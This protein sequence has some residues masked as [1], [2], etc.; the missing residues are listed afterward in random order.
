MRELFQEI[1]AT[2]RRNKLRTVLTGFSVAWGIF[3]LIILL[4]AGNGLKNGVMSNFSDVSLNSVTVYGARTDKPYKGHP[5]GRYIFFEREDVGVLQ[6]KHEDNIV[7]ITGRF[8][9][10]GGGKTAVNG[11]EYLPVSLSGIEANYTEIGILRLEEGRMINQTDIDNRRKVLIIEQYTTESLFKDASPIG[12]EIVIDNVTYTVVGRYKGG[13]R[14]N[15]PTIFAPA[16][17]LQSLYANEKPVSQIQFL[18]DGLPDEK[19]NVQFNESVRATLA[20]QRSFDPTDRWAVRI[21][22]NLRGYLQAMMIFDGINLFVWIIGLGTLLAGIVGVS[23]IMLVTVRERTSEFGIRKSMGASPASLVVLVLLESV[24][25]TAFFGYVGMLF[26]IG[27]MEGI[28]FLLEKQAAASDS[29]M[30]IF[31]NP[32]LDIGVVVSSTLVLV[33]SGMI[34]G[35]VP[36]RRAARLKTI[37]A[38]RY[39]K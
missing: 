5:N 34:A 31:K 27:V 26:G 4:G 8:N 1:F 16:S 30:V 9:A 19:S 7:K 23:N 35:Y 25:I 3:M 11:K 12:R 17:T 38:M 33:V 37:D 28:N 39:N 13:S 6:D 2:I 18:V 24:M 14:S 20:A 22:N 32:T 15:R 29:D 10:R 36:A 21:S